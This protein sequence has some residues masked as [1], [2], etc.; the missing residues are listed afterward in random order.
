MDPYF[1]PSV[2]S[3]NVICCIVNTFLFIRPIHLLSK[4]LDTST[5]THV[6]KTVSELRLLSIK[7]CILSCVATVSTIVAM[8]GIAETDY[9]AAIWLPFDWILTLSSVILM[10]SWNNKYTDILCCCLYSYAKFTQSSYSLSEF[11]NSR[12]ATPTTETG[13]TIGS[14]VNSMVIHEYSVKSV[15]VKSTKSVAIDMEIAGITNYKNE[16][17]A[18]SMVNNP[19]KLVKKISN[20]VSNRL[21]KKNSKTELGLK[22][23]LNLKNSTSINK[24]DEMD[25]TPQFKLKYSQS[26]TV[27]TYLMKTHTRQKTD[28]NFN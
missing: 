19:L 2:T 28:E 18:S 23:Q 27:P 15:T 17:K 4:K 8:V 5:S 25:D 3:L 16:V 14:N 7:Q 21:T 1:R 22:D 9:S 11:V 12:K 6:D 10:Y 24:F 20:Q 13:T 26:E